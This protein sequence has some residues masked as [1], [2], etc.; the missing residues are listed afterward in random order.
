MVRMAVSPNQK[1]WVAKLPAVEFAINLARSDTTGY[2][3]FFLNSGRMPKPF[4]YND[5]ELTEFEGVRVFAQRIKDAVESRYSRNESSKHD[6]QI[7]IVVPLLSV[8]TT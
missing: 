8:S 1:D 2:A 7:D 6:S 5:P 4:I 3:P